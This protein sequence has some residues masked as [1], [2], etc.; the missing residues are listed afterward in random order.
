MI[1]APYSEGRTVS[2]VTRR[3][4]SSGTAGR[5]LPNGGSPCKVDRA[6]STPELVSAFR[7]PKDLLNLV[8]QIGDYEAS[9]SPPSP[10]FMSA[11]DDVKDMSV[12]RKKSRWR[13]Y[14]S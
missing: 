12:T 9:A 8:I 14:P 2:L 3:N 10:S 7:R 4:L 5:W 11:S 6:A 13:P 1:N